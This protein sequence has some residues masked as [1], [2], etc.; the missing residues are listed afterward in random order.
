MR[1]REAGL[2]LVEV[3]VALFILAVLA[4]L[5]WRTV[6][7]MTD[8]RQRLDDSG[9]R[10]E[11]L[12]AAVELIEQDLGFVVE[13]AGEFRGDGGEGGRFGELRFLRGGSAYREP[14]EAGQ[15]RIG[16]RLHAG[17][18]EKLVYPDVWMVATEP[19]ARVI[20]DAGLRGL[21][22]RFRDRAGNW[23]PVWPAEA[24][25][26]L[27]RAVEARFLLAEGGEISRVF[28]LP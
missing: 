8:T 21:Y 17:R 2:T 20:L 9:R 22:F 7:A 4:V 16:Y 12:V 6:A 1:C 3:L 5:S 14:A 24:T 23:R 25:T 13:A 10:F 19:D 27:P 15:R 18:L 28:L 11:R 26:G